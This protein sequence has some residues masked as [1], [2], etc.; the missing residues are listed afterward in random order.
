VIPV[1]RTNRMPCRQRR[2]YTGRGPGDRSGHAGSSGSIRAH[3]PSST[4][5]GFLLTPS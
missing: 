4:I 5:Q 3:N 2:S 1:Y